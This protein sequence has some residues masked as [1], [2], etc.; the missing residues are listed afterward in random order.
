ML[1]FSSFIQIFSFVQDFEGL[2]KF[3]LVAEP[4]EFH[5]AGSSAP[6]ISA[7]SIYNIVDDGISI[8]DGFDQNA[9]FEE[10]SEEASEEVQRKFQRTPA[11][12][13]SSSL[14]T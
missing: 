10:V 2:N 12:S 5:S 1:L 11:S 13:S 3:I 7:S 4:V 6:F 8:Y 14:A 9:S